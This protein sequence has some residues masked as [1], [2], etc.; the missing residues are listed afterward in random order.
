[1]H[2]PTLEEY[3]DFKL[4]PRSDLTQVLETAKTQTQRRIDFITLA[5]ESI[6]LDNIRSGMVRRFVKFCQETKMVPSLC[7]D[8]T[9]S[10]AEM[11]HRTPSNPLG[12]MAIFGAPFFDDYFKSFRSH[13]GLSDGK[14]KPDD[15]WRKM[16]IQEVVAFATT[17][18]HEVDPTDFQ[19]VFTV[20]HE[21]HSGT[22]C[23]F[24]LFF[25]LYIYI[26]VFINIGTAYIV[27]LGLLSHL[28]HVLSTKSAYNR[29]DHSQ[30]IFEEASNIQTS[31]INIVKKFDS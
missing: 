18:G 2:N 19:E 15:S 28:F 12:P 3:G 25:I 24:P 8:P 6:A 4:L 30:D 21:K 26:F 17:I 11:V 13:V 9:M 16:I 23:L 29:D 7:V 20:L 22:P 27:W 10:R 5:H 14:R 1:M 31:Q